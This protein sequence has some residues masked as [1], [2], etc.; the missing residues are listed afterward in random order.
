M[1]RF[2][3]SYLADKG[4]EEVIT[5]KADT[6]SAARDAI[7]T[8]G[9]RNWGRYVIIAEDG[10]IAERGDRNPLGVA[11]PETRC[12]QCGAVKLPSGEHLCVPK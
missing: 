2:E 12:D 11:Y 1:F 7:C 3:F 6:L 10:T 5:G 4:V 8:F 9:P